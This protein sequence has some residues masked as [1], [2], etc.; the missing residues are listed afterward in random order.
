MG[1]GGL[2][3]YPPIGPPAQLSPPPPRFGRRPT[4][5]VSLG[6]AVPLGLSVALAIDFVMVLVARLLFGAAL[7]GAFLSLYVAREWGVGCCGAQQAVCCGMRAVGCCEM[8]DPAGCRMLQQ[9]A[10]CGV[11]DAVGC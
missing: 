3:G 6:L 2:A 8:R 4:F 7:A 9:V 1:R 10:C 11:Q 5:L